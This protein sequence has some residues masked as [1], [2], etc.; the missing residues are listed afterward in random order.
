[1]A[2]PHGW[3]NLRGR[4]RM[5]RIRVFPSAGSKLN[6]K[7]GRPGLLLRKSLVGISLWTISAIGNR[8]CATQRRRVINEKRKRRRGHDF[9]VR[10]VGNIELIVSLASERVTSRFRPPYHGAATIYSIGVV[11]M[12]GPGGN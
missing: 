5:N 2:F 1:M 6:V 4:R 12:N 10:N 11:L 9:G 8:L 7:I 3:T